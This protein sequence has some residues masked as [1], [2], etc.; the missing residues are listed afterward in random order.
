MLGQSRIQ[1]GSGSK[2]WF[3]A[4]R[5]QNELS[6]P[7][8]GFVCTAKFLHLVLRLRAKKIRGWTGIKNLD[9]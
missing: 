6:E 7:E 1:D 2:P 4:G 3:N 8:S 9:L 5:L